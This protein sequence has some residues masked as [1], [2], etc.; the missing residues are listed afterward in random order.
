MENRRPLRTLGP[1]A[2][3]L[4]TPFEYIALLT[5][6]VI[7]PGI[8]RVLTGLGRILQLRHGIK[9]YWVHLLW[10]GNVFLW[11]LH[12]WWILYRWRAFDLWSF[13]LFLFVLISPVVAFLLSVL[14]VPD[15]LEAGEDLKRHYYRNSRWFFLLAALLPPVDAVDTLLKG[16]AHF[17]AQ[18]PI[19]VV[20]LS[21][22]FVLCLIAAFTKNEIFHGGFS[23]FFLIY[24]R[25]SS[26]ST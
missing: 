2:V 25:H 3:R 8:T 4:V 23:V 15:P 21:L 17:A 16:Q 9:V 26:R 6:I 20:T 1:P 12:N 13:F 5:S 19:Y 24:L 11:L 14:L 22:I 10:I 18:G 7:A